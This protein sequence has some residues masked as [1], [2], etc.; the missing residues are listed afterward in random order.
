MARHSKASTR[1]GPASQPIH[2]EGAA[3]GCWVGLHQDLI[4]WSGKREHIPDE[5]TAAAAAKELKE[6]CWVGLKVVKGR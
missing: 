5:G 1:M 4:R 2:D 3:A 6:G